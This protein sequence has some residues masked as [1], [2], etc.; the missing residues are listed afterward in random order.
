MM[1]LLS[2]KINSPLPVFYSENTKNKNHKMKNL[3]NLFI[4][5]VNTEIIG[6]TTTEFEAQNYVKSLSNSLKRNNYIEVELFEEN[7]INLLQKGMIKNCLVYTIH[8]K[9]INKL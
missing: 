4:V 5:L 7:K 9:K 2:D 1:S 3:E 6:Y 8:Y